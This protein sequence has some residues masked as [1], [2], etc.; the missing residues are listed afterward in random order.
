MTYYLH[1]LKLA[2]RSPPEKPLRVVC[3]LVEGRPPVYTPALKVK[4][5]LRDKQNGVTMNESP[6]WP[7]NSRKDEE[8]RTE[9]QAEGAGEA[10]PVD[11]DGSDAEDGLGQAVSRQE[12]GTLQEY[13]D[14][15]MLLPPE[16][17]WDGESDNELI[18]DG[19][20]VMTQATQLAMDQDEGID[21]MDEESDEDY[22]VESESGRENSGS[23]LDYVPNKIRGRRK[24]HKRS[25]AKNTEGR[26]AGPHKT[27]K[28]KL[29][30]RTS[31][32]RPQYEFCPLPHC[33]S[34]I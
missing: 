29:K 23:D 12:G 15:A 2:A 13:E 10:G 11:D 28:D 3:L 30:K 9:R 32:H 24:H 22:D 34:I 27:A 16:P 20:N 4:L 6:P 7:K 1:H 14:D 31:Q 26:A 25:I 21:K 5:S 19:F 8:M 33:L 18:S 17:L